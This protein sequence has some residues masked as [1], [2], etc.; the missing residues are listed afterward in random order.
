MSTV[1]LNLNKLSFEKQAPNLIC[2]DVSHSGNQI[3]RVYKVNL[4]IFWNFRTILT[5]GR[6]CKFGSQ[7]RFPDWGA[8]N[9]QNFRLLRN[10]CVGFV[11]KT[12]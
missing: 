10:D 12:S 2:L 6:G 7:R 11:Q 3:L 4:F 9:L 5:F 8:L 1:F